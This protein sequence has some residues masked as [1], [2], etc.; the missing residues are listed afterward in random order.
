MCAGNALGLSYT[1]T[2]CGFLY[3]IYH[4]DITCFSSLGAAKADA[5]SMHGSDVHDKEIYGGLGG[6]GQY[7]SAVDV[8]RSSLGIV[9][10]QCVCVVVIMRRLYVSGFWIFLCWLL[11]MWPP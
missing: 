8:G 5:V 11:W 6:I 10:G 1:Y 7:Y 3:T 2:I 4:Y 9:S